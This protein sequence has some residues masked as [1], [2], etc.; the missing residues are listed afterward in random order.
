M[1]ESSKKPSD[2]P[3]GD[4]R[5][6]QEN[7]VPGIKPGQRRGPDGKLLPKRAEEPEA[8]APAKPPDPPLSLAVEDELTAM[9]FVW[10]NP[11]DRTYQHRSFR[12]MKDGGPL[13][14]WDRLQALKKER[15]KQEEAGRSQGANV[16]PEWDGT[17]PC[18][19]C[20]HEPEQPLDDEGTNKI[21]AM[22]DELDE[23]E[24]GTPA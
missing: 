6:G 23:R 16:G 4:R 5:A 1:P 11:T 14:F 9:E 21:L 15:A 10:N 22:L 8:P 2:L 12:A 3:S 20:G 18:P 19:T 17:W 13:G 24:K 7:L